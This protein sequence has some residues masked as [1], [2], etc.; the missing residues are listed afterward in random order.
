MATSVLIGNGINRVTNDDAS[1]ENVLRALTPQG[2]S[3][4]ALE[5]MKHKPFALVYEEILLTRMSHDKKVDEA[6]MKS[7]I[8]Q[9]VDGLRYNDFHRRVMASGVRHIITTNY[10]YGFEKATRQD[11]PHAHLMRESKYSVFRRRASGEKFVWHIHGEV[12]APNTI[13]LGYDQYSGYLQKLRTYATADRE[14]ATGS[15]FKMGNMV[16]D[17]VPGTVYSWLDVFLRDDIH[18]AGLGLDYTEIDLWWA[19]TYKARKKA[20]GLPVGRTI[21]HDWYMGEVDEQALSRRSLMRVLSVDVIPRDCTTG[22]E[23]AWDEFITGN[24]EAP[25]A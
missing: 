19:V 12:E 4:P 13:T 24:L 9:L 17:H 7:T 3:L 25:T 11:H 2:L 10:D 1:W 20:Q 5:H 15:P 14:S 18:I 16:F 21:Y 22:F 23:P 8:A 6:A